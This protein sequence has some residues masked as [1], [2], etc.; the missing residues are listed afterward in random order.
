MAPPVS[1][2]AGIPPKAS[3]LYCV[4]FT[5]LCFQLGPVWKPSSPQGSPSFP[6]AGSPRGILSRGVQH[7]PLEARSVGVS[8]PSEPNNPVKL[9][10]T[11]THRGEVPVPRLASRSREVEQQ[12]AAAACRSPPTISRRPFS[13]AGVPAATSSFVSGDSPSPL[14]IPIH[15]SAPARVSSLLSSHLFLIDPTEEVLRSGADHK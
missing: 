1:D 15:L 4:F 14:S 12:S 6:R 3:R 2:Y 8:G 7:A 11:Y 10:P 9:C 5:A 13:S